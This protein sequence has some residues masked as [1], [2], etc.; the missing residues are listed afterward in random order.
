MQPV[1]NID[2]LQSSIRDA[3][4]GAKGFLTNF[5]APTSVAETWIARGA[6]EVEAFEG[7]TLL[8][9]RDQDFRHLYYAAADADALSAALRRRTPGSGALTADLIGRPEEAD[10]L[11]RLFAEHGFARHTSLVRMCRTAQQSVDAAAPRTSGGEFARAEDAPAIHAFLRRLLDRFAE[12]LPEIEDLEA[13]CA[14][15]NVLVVRRGDDLGGVLIFETTGVTSVLRYWF[16]NDRYR[17]QGIGASL[18][19][20][21]FEACR[22]SRRILLWVISDNRDAIAK[23]EHYRFSREGLVDHIVINRGKPA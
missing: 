18:I 3:R 23:Y 7:C 8:Y 6:L 9:R 5:F 12:Q 20:P 10:A 22:A 17:N 2:A 19:H 1:A 14:R 15:R 21:F 4:R 13:D 16:V 11:A